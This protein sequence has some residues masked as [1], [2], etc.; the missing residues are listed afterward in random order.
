[1]VHYFTD[2]AEGEVKTA[3]N[4]GLEEAMRNADQL[5]VPQ[6]LIADQW[7]LPYVYTIF[8]VRFPPDRFQREVQFKVIRGVYEVKKVGKYIFAEDHLD[9]SKSYGYLSR[10]GWYDVERRKV[11]FQNDL[12]EVGIVE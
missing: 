5:K 7:S 4:T 2:Y 10:K 11:L 12:W 8:F 9:R 6:L 3:F 1:M